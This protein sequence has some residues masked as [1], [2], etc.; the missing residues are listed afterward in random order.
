M[1]SLSLFISEHLIT[2]IPLGKK[3][4]SKISEIKD[5]ITCTPFGLYIL[6]EKTEPSPPFMYRNPFLYEIQRV[7][8]SEYA[9]L[10]NVGV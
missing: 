3:E 4:M 9:F 7:N 5:D 1:I 2:Y 10:I 6:I 8:V